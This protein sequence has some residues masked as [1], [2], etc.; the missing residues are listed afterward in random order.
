MKRSLTIVYVTARERP[1]LEWFLDSLRMQIPPGEHHNINVTVV[2]SIYSPRIPRWDLSSEPHFNILRVPPKPTIWQG[3]HRITKEEW[4]AASSARNTGICLCR[5]EWIAF[6]D[7]RCVLLPGYLQS[8]SEAMVG[9]YAV[10]GSYQKRTGMKV[11]NGVIAHGGIITGQD[12][13]EDYVKQW[14]ASVTPAKCPGEWAF[15][16]S[17]ALPLEWALQVNGYDETCDG[18]S[19]EDVIFGLHLQNNGFDLRYDYRSKMIEDRTPS[20]LG[21]AMRRED[22]GVSPNDKSHA[23][24]ALLR[25]RKTANNSFDIR[26]L[27]ESVLAGNPWPIPTGPTHDWF[28]NQP[29]SEFK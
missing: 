9:N 28:D 3:E 10:F 21:K 26:Q 22:K 11:E 20:E 17:L 13:R 12:H 24:L 27:R 5:T 23:L 6:L 29:I 25:D 4:W 1:C 7:D 8:I 16:C 15:G 19:M 2:D 14:W 18:L